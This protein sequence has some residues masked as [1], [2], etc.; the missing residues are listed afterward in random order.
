MADT[1]TTYQGRGP[2]GEFSIDL[3]G[4]ATEMTQQKVVK[5]LDNLNKKFKTFPKDVGDAFK[6]ALKGNAKALNELNKQTKQAVK[7]EKNANARNK[8]HQSQTQKAQDAMVQQM[9]QNAQA[10]KDLED[11]TKKNQA[12]GG[13]SLLDLATKAGPLAKGFNALTKVA[14]LVGKVLK[15]LFVAASTL[16]TFLTREF[17]KVFNLLNDSLADGTGAILGAFTDSAVNIGAEASKAGLGIKDFV[18]AIT[19]N[20]EEIRVLGARGFRDLRNQVVDAKDGLYD[21]GMTQDEITKLLGREMSIRARLGVQL[22]Q[23]GRDLGEN[24]NQVGR[25]LRML[26][27]AAGINAEVLYEASKQSDET[28][29]LIAA[30]ARQFG[31]E[32]INALN[33]AVRRLTMRMVALSPTFGKSISEPLV[34]AMVTGAIGLDQGFTDLI[35]VMPGLANAFRMGRDEIMSSSNISESTIDRMVESMTAVS[36]EEFNRAKMLALMTRN[37]NALQLVQFASEA[38]ARKSLLDAINDSGNEGA[39]QTL[40]NAATISAQFEIFIDAIKAPFENSITTFAAAFLGVNLAD[41][42]VNL[43]SL[44]LAFSQKAQEFI[45][46]IPL[47]GNVLDSDFFVELDNFIT[48]FFDPNSSE[49]KKRDARAKFNAILTDKIT[50]FGD[51]LGDALADNNLGQ[52][53]AKMFQDVIDEIAI[54]VFEA[55]NGRFMSESAGRAYMRQG[56]LGKALEIEEKIGADHMGQHLRNQMADQMETLLSNTTGSSD[57]EMFR[58]E[59]KYRSGQMTPYEEKMYLKDRTTGYE[60]MSDDAFEDLHT[61]MSRFQEIV[62]IAAERSGVNLSDIG[63]SGNDLFDADDLI[64]EA[65][66]DALGPAAMFLQEMYSEDLQGM[67][68]NISIGSNDLIDMPGFKGSE[69]MGKGISVEARP[70]N[71]NIL[72]QDMLRIIPNSQ[73]MFAQG[74][75]QNFLQSPQFLDII[76]DGVIDEFEALRLTGG[77]SMLE[78]PEVDANGN[79]TG[80]MISMEGYTQGLF[81]RDFLDNL[82]LSVEESNALR[83]E[84]RNFLSTLNKDG[85][86]SLPTGYE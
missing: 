29:A 35:T 34:N 85:L 62:N 17:F 18:D 50:E 3:P 60:T 13:G 5:Q 56:N 64:R 26:G 82:K 45:N 37:Q 75:L 28:N 23:S 51:S 21:L 72:N 71:T 39:S 47:L 74:L 68:E 59:A 57:I 36:E 24:I 81:D 27:N 55:T 52:T 11:L 79:P 10:L 42:D 49:E 22:D 53:I 67:L 86:L 14:G 58:K 73:D 83:R 70:G 8:K 33:S 38:R 25:D 40:R 19:A 76:K 12:A 6:D 66:K 63:A 61:R 32:G 84:F 65:R 16:A 4:W 41:K 69:G 20:S 2:D 7:D 31:N 30:R 54:N 80:N 48:S 15:G 43:G 9:F 46:K 1:L 78:I 44:V 77:S